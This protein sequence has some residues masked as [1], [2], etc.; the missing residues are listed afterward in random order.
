MTPA[1]LMQLYRA[2]A[3]QTPTST[4]ATSSFT[5]ESLMELYRS[6]AAPAQPAMAPAAVP[7]PP[8]QPE[9][10]YGPAAARGLATGRVMA[11]PIGGA[12]AL[13]SAA[14][15][16]G[17]YISEPLG[18]AF[19]AYAENP[20]RRLLG[21]EEADYEA[22]QAA[23]EADPIVRGAKATLGFLERLPFAIGEQVGGLFGESGPAV[24]PEEKIF[25]RTAELL[26]SAGRSALRRPVSS[27]A[28]A[29]ATAA[30]GELGEAV[31]GAPGRLV[32]E[33]AV[34]T[35]AKLM[36]PQQAVR[37]NTIEGIRARRGL[38]TDRGVP[39]DR[40]SLARELAEDVTKQRSIRA[41]EYGKAFDA[42]EKKLAG[43]ESM[44]VTE[45]QVS[46]IRRNVAT[47]RNLLSGVPPTLLEEPLDITGKSRMTLRE[48][49]EPIN[50]A[51]ERGDVIKKV[52]PTAVYNY[53][54]ALQRIVN[55]VPV[56]AGDPKLLYKPIIKQLYSLFSHKKPVFGSDITS[57]MSKA[58]KNWAELTA[59][60][61]D[62]PG[63]KGFFVANADPE[64]AL[65]A[66][67]TQ[68]GAQDARRVLS[69]KG[70]DALKRLTFDEITRGDA[71][72]GLTV[73]E[74][75]PY[76]AAALGPEYQPLRRELESAVKRRSAIDR[77]IRMVDAL[78]GGAAG[79][80]AIASASVPGLVGKKAI[81]SLVKR[82]IPGIVDADLERI[83]EILSEVDV[84]N[85]L[86]RSA[87]P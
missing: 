51:F 75:D 19:T 12:S 69:S 39:V 25:E 66:L 37:T 82:M 46:R 5:P 43:V 71:D 81:Q 52:S 79:D 72:Q 4:P 74:R 80:I 62:S 42:I 28:R 15:L 24:E 77:K 16:G 38:P 64:K 78:T 54:R 11:T 45:R 36:Q 73:L 1:E 67:R 47:V 14:R 8:A 60:F 10:A 17:E 87:Q 33:L 20:L 9:F 3:T 76:Y 59:D 53:A 68:T 22:R 29:G 18:R 13:A 34:G 49:L 2:G 50:A 35:G 86:I 41:R 65:G 61:V 56:T 23:H 30:G 83:A 26:G 44:P 48:A 84:R 32:G 27:L 40:A 70:R 6:G 31:G 63:L 57:E 21:M 58:R 85:T 55:N 7:P